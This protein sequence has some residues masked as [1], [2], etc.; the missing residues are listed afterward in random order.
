MKACLKQY[1]RQAGQ[2]LIEI[3]IT[4]G[5]LAILFHAVF[6]L[7]TAS[8]RLLGDSR[9]RLTA[10]HI[11]QAKIEEIRNLPFD[12]V[13]T[14]GGIPPGII[15]QSET[16]MRNGLNYVSRTSVIY[17][18]DE[19]DKLAPVDLLP[20]DYKRVRVEVSW[21]GLFASKRPVVALT[22][23]TPRGIESTTGGGT[24]RITVF[25][26]SV[27]M[28]PAT[29]IHIVNP[30]VNPAI[31][32]IIYTNEN[33]QVLL[34]GAPVCANCY[35]ISATKQ[36]Y[37]T[38]RTYS[39]EE[40][41][42]PNKAYLTVSEG[43]VSDISFTIDWTSTLTIKTFADR[44]SGFPPLG[45]AEFHLR[46]TRRI[47]TDTEEMPVYLVD[48]D[49]TTAE[50]GELVLEDMVWDSYQFTLGNPALDLAGSNPFVPLGLLPNQE[51]NLLVATKAH[52]DHTLLLS[53]IDASGSAIASAGAHL[54]RDGGLDEFLFTGSAENPD[55]GQGFF[56][57]L[58]IGEYDY[59]V[60]A[61]AYQTSSGTIEV[62]GQSSEII[63]LQAE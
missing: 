30:N 39:S 45:Q 3:I 13:G 24:I 19:F 26:A 31:D 63:I 40:V 35:Y 29:E 44:D 43:L 52:Q 62:D 37:T 32:L 47:G 34:P 38:D 57:A 25:N 58:D 56:S 55:F 41:A 51:L 59:E 16:A 7:I 18:D 1:R 50:T 46:G 27:E 15:T 36:G 14:V 20:I 8:F 33:G 49:Y 12:D 17:I 22:D 11:A 23:I 54:T 6:T 42:N 60:T 53:V 28:L 5:L 2:T 10:R 4:I 21:S 9:A 61:S 48:A